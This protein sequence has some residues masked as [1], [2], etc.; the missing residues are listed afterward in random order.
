VRILRVRAD[1][2]WWEVVDRETPEASRQ[3]VPMENEGRKE[4]CP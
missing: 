3:M 2:W 1:P 4:W